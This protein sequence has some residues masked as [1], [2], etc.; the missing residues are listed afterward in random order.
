MLSSEQIAPPRQIE[1]QPNPQ[2]QLT[3]P[4]MPRITSSRPQTV[5]RNRPDSRRKIAALFPPPQTRNRSHSDPLPHLAASNGQ[6]TSPRPQTRTRSHSDPLSHL[7]AS[8]RQATSSQPQATT[9]SNVSTTPGMEGPSSTGPHLENVGRP[10]G[11]LE[12]SEI[13]EGTA[14]QEASTDDLGKSVS[15]IPKDTEM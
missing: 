12:L 8:N 7:A 2:P 10:I 4:K 1:E 15:A 6:I 9:K 14:I 13:P 5:I 3:A 11:N